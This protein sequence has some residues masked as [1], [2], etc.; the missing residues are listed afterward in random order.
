M[1]HHCG[2]YKTLDPH[3]GLYFIKQIKFGQVYILG[4]K[5]NTINKVDKKN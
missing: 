3:K 1:F 4:W 2:L 5:I